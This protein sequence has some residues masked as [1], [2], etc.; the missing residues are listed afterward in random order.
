MVTLGPPRWNGVP[1]HV[2]EGAGP[3]QQG[4]VPT[5]LG[6]PGGRAPFP[7][8]PPSASRPNSRLAF[9]KNR[10]RGRAERQSSSF[11][12]QPGCQGLPELALAVSMTTGVAPAPSASGKGAGFGPAA[13]ELRPP[14]ELEAPPQPGPQSKIPQHLIIACPHLPHVFPDAPSGHPVTLCCPFLASLSL[15]QKRELPHVLPQIPTPSSPG[16]GSSL[17]SPNS[18]SEAPS[19]SR[20]CPMRISCGSSPPRSPRCSHIPRHVLFTG[21]QL[22]PLHVFPLTPYCLSYPQIPLTPKLLDSP[23]QT[24]LTSLALCSHVPLRA[25][26]AST[27]TFPQVPPSLPSAHLSQTAGH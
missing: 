16:P 20:F 3:G 6:I 8:C 4:Q 10:R 2:P 19:P 11:W 25:L 7:G 13:L 21:S 17:V 1:S 12:Q 26:I 24:P 27:L 14:E 23:V 5:T 18:S 15:G 22:Q 9:P